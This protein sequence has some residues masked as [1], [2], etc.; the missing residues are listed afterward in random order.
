MT[1]GDNIKR[2]RKEKGLTQK[3]LAELLKVTPQ[4]LAQYEN[5]RRLPKRETINKI[6]NALEVDSVDLTDDTNEVNIVEPSIDN[7]REEIRQLAYSLN[8]SGL[9]KVKEYM[10]DIV[11]NPKYKIGN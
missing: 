1:I 8:E 4:N 11:V 3:K 10:Y 9:R 5:G 2:I 7:L 6:A